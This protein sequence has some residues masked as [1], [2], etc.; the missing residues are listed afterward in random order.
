MF[1]ERAPRMKLTLHEK[2]AL[3]G[4]YN[5]RVPVP[6][7]AQQIGCHT[8]TVKKWVNRYQVT[9]D[10]K[11]KVGSGGPRKTTQKQDNMLLQAVRAKPLTSLQELKGL[12]LKLK[13]YLVSPSHLP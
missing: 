12:E 10:V 13:F 5:S 9:N 6:N 4:R 2:G 3:I 1:R 11:R 8:N 7:I